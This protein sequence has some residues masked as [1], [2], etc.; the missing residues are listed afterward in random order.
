[1]F[2]IKFSMYFLNLKRLIFSLICKM[3]QII[4]PYALLYLIWHITFKYKIFW[5][6]CYDANSA[7]SFEDNEMKVVFLWF[8]GTFYFTLLHK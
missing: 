2:V 1:L 3:C 7:F 4:L 8:R 5:T 6:K